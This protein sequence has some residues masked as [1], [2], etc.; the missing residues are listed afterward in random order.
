MRIALL[1]FILSFNL[2]AF[3]ECQHLIEECA[4]YACVEGI[5]KCGERKYFI[6]F[7]L[8]YCNSFDFRSAKFSEE[9]K[10]WLD[11][12]K[13]CLIESIDS[14][15]ESL[16]CRK[17]KKASISS[18]V[19][20]YV[21]SGYCNLSFRDKKEVIKTIKGALWRPSILRAGLK[22]NFKCGKV[23]ELPFAQ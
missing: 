2:Y 8:K 23:E 4:Y 7:G 15:D 5:K 16:S 22:I 3:E 9:G 11:D 6:G 12:V 14:L 13:S 1:A 10:L 19:N 18:H 21:K 17:L 20:C